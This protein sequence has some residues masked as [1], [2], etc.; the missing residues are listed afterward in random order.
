MR[1]HA[2]RSVYYVVGRGVVEEPDF[3]SN[4]FHPTA[5]AP[6]AADEK[7][8]PRQPREPQTV[9]KYGSMFRDLPSVASKVDPKE[10]VDKLIKLGQSMNVATAT[11]ESPE[12]ESNLPAGYTYLG[13]FIAH[14][15][16]FDKTE[17][18]VFGGLRPGNY[19][20]PQID[21]D[22]LY[23]R[24]PIEDPHLYEDAARLKVGETH[25]TGFV[26]RTFLNDLPRAGFGSE[27]PKRALIAD[28]R[29]DDNLALAQMHVAFAKFHNKVVDELDQ[30]NHFYLL[31]SKHKERCPTE[32]LFTCARRA[33][34]QHFHAIILWDYL[35]RILNESGLERVRSGKLEFFDIDGKEGVFMPLE[36]S[37]AAFRFGHS[38]IRSKYHWNE[39]HSGDK[40]IDL[41]TLFKFTQFSG[42]LGQSPRLKSEWLIDWRRF[43]DFTEL[44]FKDDKR[45]KN[46]A[47]KIDTSFNL[48]LNEI[49]GYPHGNFPKEQ[50]AITV[51]NLLRGY[52]LGL[53]S[54]E[55]V[56]ECIKAPWRLTRQEIVCGPHEDVLQDKAFEGNTPLWY[57]ILREAEINNRTAKTSQL[58]PVG[59]CIVA[60]TLLGLIKKSADSVLN[61]PEW[62]PKFGR[63]LP[64]KSYRMVDLLNFVDA[65]DPVGDFTKLAFAK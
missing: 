52:S 4:G 3:L 36:F 43:F 26:K 63:L 45:E 38:M 2:D 48:H 53:P 5:V 59:S 46:F 12:E 6:S 19:R 30:V 41:L 50:Q 10:M 13:Q 7:P 28:P 56:A 17:M 9:G 57:Y 40:A 35:P 25:G 21:L 16:S 32:E 54:G 58:G 31:C 33:V 24:G 29:N 20:S 37:V 51:R 55:Q 61:D 11:A 14:E 34:V 49:S 8:K 44:G 62:H 47:R 39:I 23:G 65:L 64:P 18:P 60:E 15:L 42:D 27:D 1:R 22:S